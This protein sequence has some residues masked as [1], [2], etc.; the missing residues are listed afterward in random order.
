M[1]M[2]VIKQ[3]LADVEWGDLD[4]LVVDAPPGTGDEPLSVCQLIED[5]DGA[6]VVTTPQEVA[7]RRRAQVHHLLPPA[8]PCPCWASWRT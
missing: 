2:G 3:F 7:A 5:A 6:I 8:R 4:Y 1:K